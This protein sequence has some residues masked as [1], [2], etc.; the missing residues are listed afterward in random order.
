MYME[1]EGEISGN[2]GRVKRVAAGAAVVLE[3][4]PETCRLELQGDLR[5]SVKLP[6]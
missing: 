4:N 2:R 3:V 5:C 6:R 1:Y